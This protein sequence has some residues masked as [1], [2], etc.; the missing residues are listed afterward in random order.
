MVKIHIINPDSREDKEASAEEAQRIVKEAWS[1]GKLTID[2]QSRS[3]IDRV[4]EYTREIT[5]IALF[6]GG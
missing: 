3:V 4:T 2:T 6:E 5:I 1:Q